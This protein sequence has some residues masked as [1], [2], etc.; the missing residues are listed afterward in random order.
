MQIPNNRIFQLYCALIASG[1]NPGEETIK[2]AELE[3]SNFDA[4]ITSREEECP[5]CGRV[6]CDGYCY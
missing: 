5:E 6:N 4:Y 1:K 2:Q 3:L